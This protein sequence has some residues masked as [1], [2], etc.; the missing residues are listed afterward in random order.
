MIA[1]EVACIVVPDRAIPDVP[2]H[3]KSHVQDRRTLFIPAENVITL[4]RENVR[5]VVPA[6]Q[7][8]AR[9]I[10]PG[11]VKVAVERAKVVVKMHAKAPAKEIVPE[12]VVR[13]VCIPALVHAPDHV[14]AGAII[15]V[16]T[17]VK[18]LA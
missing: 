16:I 6:A 5:E 9:E 17:H 14:I 4:V 10:V 11:H 18:V 12:A 7:E 8:H 1:K 13:V 3:A 2:A 15:R